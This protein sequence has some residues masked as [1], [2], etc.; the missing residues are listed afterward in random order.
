MAFCALAKTYGKKIEYSGPWY[1]TMKVD[2]DSIWLRFDH[3]DGGL[4]GGDLKGF[5][6]A[7]IDHKFVW[8]KAVTRGNF[9]VVSSPEVP[10]PVAVRYAW[11]ANPVCNVYNQAGLP[12]V[13]FRTDDW[14]MLTRDRK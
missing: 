12:A 10:S 9:V 7:G 14:P 5:A 1:R 2:G 6:I 11:D 4:V 3:V 13:P 8:A